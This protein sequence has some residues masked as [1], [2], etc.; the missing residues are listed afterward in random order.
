MVSRVHP[1]GI[2]HRLVVFGCVVAAGAFAA[3]AN[4]RDRTDRSAEDNAT[5]HV[6]RQRGLATSSGRTMAPRGS[7]DRLRSHDASPDD[8]RRSLSQ[9]P[10]LAQTGPDRDQRA[11]GNRPQAPRSGS[12]P[13][14]ERQVAN[15]TKDS[16]RNPSRA[17]AAPDRPA[18]APRAQERPR[19][20]PS[21]PQRPAQVPRPVAPSGRPPQS[22]ERPSGDASRRRQMDPNPSRRPEVGAPRTD[23]PAPRPPTV[24]PRE[25]AG[26]NPGISQPRTPAEQPIRRN[27]A[28]GINDARPSRPQAPVQ[29]PGSSSGAA[30]PTRSSRSDAV[31]SI[32]RPPM[33]SERT[34]RPQGRSDGERTMTPSRPDRVTSPITS[35]RSHPVSRT[36]DEAVRSISRPMT[37]SDRRVTR[38]EGITRSPRQITTRQPADSVT[39]SR[40]TERSVGRGETGIG[41]SSAGRVQT[42]RVGRT[43]A[44]ARTVA[45]GSV[46]GREV[47]V[48]ASDR[49]SRRDVRVFDVGA[50]QFRGERS[51]TVVRSGDWRHG[52][53]IWGH[54]HRHWWHDRHWGHHSHV[55]VSFSFTYVHSY[56]APAR[57]VV[58]DVVPVTPVVVGPAPLVSASFTYYSAPTV[59]S[60]S[61]VRYVYPVAAVAPAVV[62]YREYV[63]PPI[64][65]P[66]VFSPIVTTPVYPAPVV[67]PVVAP[68]YAPV[69][70]Y[71]PAYTVLSYPTYYVEP[72][73]VEAPAV[74][75]TPVV[76]EQGSSWSIST[77]FGLSRNGKSFSF[78]GSFTKS[79]PPAV[80]GAAV[81]EAPAVPAPAP[82]GSADA[83][84]AAE[85]SPQQDYADDAVLEVGPPSL[86]TGLEKIRS[87]EM[88]EARKILW[89]VVSDDPNDG[90]SRMLYATA[91]AADGQYGE[92]ADALRQAL[93][94]WQDLQLKDYWLPSVYDDAQRFT[95]AMR[96]AR[97]FLSDHPERVDA[98]LLVSWGYAFS[99]ELEQA[100]ELID[101]ARRMWPDDS[102]FGTLE[103]LVR[104]G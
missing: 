8:S 28:V 42:A 79:D 103:R 34:S 83:G 86:E 14:R 89:Q 50:R 29:R 20:A 80:V 51:V 5:R 36:R 87:G 99:G 7:F 62:V 25:N 101:E 19:V 10:F 55:D 67:L 6:L 97:E 72:A 12:S 69:Y 23:A 66:V 47:Y 11:R 104:E 81:V 96:D 46:A 38:T 100:E 33:T 102:S 60:V 59:V 37:G 85:F 35:S 58:Y 54:G 98:W 4:G 90:M 82:Y 40:A 27:P 93:V 92:A 41:R 70:Y 56:F 16:P 30:A 1:K 71:Y 48:R 44:P 91:L 3:D 61:S 13:E 32:R 88:E 22:A 65:T 9:V 43:A 31:Q 78:G 39:R 21:A 75:E 63:A 2:V 49:V 45:R 76:E 84:A 53:P 94:T 26:G 18:Q 15:D 77:A 57:A 68:I 74:V 73:V 64:V 95:Q 24:R 17:P 52:R